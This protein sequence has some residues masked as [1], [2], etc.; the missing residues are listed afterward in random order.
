[1][2]CDV[3]GNYWSGGGGAV[4]SPPSG[5]APAAA[6]KRGDRDE[7]R[8]ADLKGA[9]GR[10]PDDVADRPPWPRSFWAAAGPPGSGHRA[11]QGPG[12]GRGGCGAGRGGPP[13]GERGKQRGRLG[14]TQ[15]EKNQR[16]GGRDRVS[17]DRVSPGSDPPSREPGGP[18]R[19]DG[20][21]A[22]VYSGI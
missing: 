3:P 16:R 7:T 13:L 18:A 21:Y 17:A 20:S 19:S 14:S 15:R 5:T 22:G 11:N 10:G 1:M 4:G 9:K 12:K 2:P 6:G 8:K